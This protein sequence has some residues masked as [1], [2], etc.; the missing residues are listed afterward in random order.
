MVSPG[1]SGMRDGIFLGRVLG[2]P[3]TSD[4][5]IF[6]TIKNMIR[7]TRVGVLLAV[8]CV[9][10][11]FWGLLEWCRKA[12]VV[13]VAR[14]SVVEDSWQCPCQ[15]YRCCFVSVCGF[16]PWKGIV[17]VFEGGITRLSYLAGCG[18]DFYFVT[19]Q[20]RA[21]RTQHVFTTSSRRA[22]QRCYWGLFR[23]T[24]VG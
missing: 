14:T 16:G 7:M 6:D 21:S 18:C 10:L 23:K 8:R 3:L 12:R 20:R 2:G 4:A 24:G 1:S 22:G 13:A 17:L 5:N 19:A 9:W 11:L 15:M